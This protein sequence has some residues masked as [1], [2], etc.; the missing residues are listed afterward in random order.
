MIHLLAALLFSVFLFLAC[1]HIYWGLGGKWGSV[2][3]IHTKANNKKLMSPG[4]V[5]CFIVASGLLGFGIFVMIKAAIFRLDMADGLSR[6]GLWIISFIFLLRALG[7]FRYV[8]LFKKIKTTVFGRMDTKYFT[9]LCIVIGLLT[10]VCRSSLH[11]RS[12]KGAKD[13]KK[14]LLGVLASLRG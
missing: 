2:A 14:R 10:I 9:P 1:V 5:S 11:K 7:D 13:A 8:G 3:A 6:Y 4:L 12:R